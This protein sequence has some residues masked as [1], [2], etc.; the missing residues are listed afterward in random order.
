MLTEKR[1]KIY[2]Q[3]PLTGS[4]VPGPHRRSLMENRSLTAAASRRCHGDP[5]PPRGG[6]GGR[7]VYLYTGEERPI[8]R[9]S[10]PQGGRDGGRDGD[11]DPNTAGLMKGPS[12]LLCSGGGS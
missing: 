7:P 9:W 1:G 10:A 11:S 2:F 3:I 5:P 8:N 6:E 4:L 12:T